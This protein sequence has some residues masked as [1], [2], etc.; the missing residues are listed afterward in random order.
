M[1]AKTTLRTRD[2]RRLC[3]VC[4]KHPARFCFRGVVKRDRQHDLC[5]HCWRS[6]RNQ[7]KAAAL[8]QQ[9]PASYEGR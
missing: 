9:T 3:R 5:F 4:G 7:I 2:L 1:S 6:M 8:S